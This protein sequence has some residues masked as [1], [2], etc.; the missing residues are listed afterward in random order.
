TST[1]SHS[2]TTAAPA[3]FTW[4][5]LVTSIATPSALPPPRL[6]SLATA[7]AASL[8]RSAMATRAPSRA[9]RR[10][11][12]LPMPLAAPVTMQTLLRR[13]MVQDSGRF[14]NGGAL[15]AHEVEQAHAVV[16]R[17]RALGPA[18]ILQRLQDVGAAGVPVLAHG[19]P[20][21]LV[22]LR[23]ALVAL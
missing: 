21:E 7:W 1:P 17:R 13:F 23:V 11:I 15:R 18:R 20:R 16:L 2:C 8:F 10:A 5:S 12:S 4:S 9:K 6:I 14:G 3:A 22:V 19:E